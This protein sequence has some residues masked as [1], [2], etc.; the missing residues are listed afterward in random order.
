MV[1]ADIAETTARSCARG[2]M[3]PRVLA[4]NLGGVDEI[5]SRF[6]K[7]PEEIMKYNENP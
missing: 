5:Q 2:L 7:K 1:Q 3:L 4:H 6:P